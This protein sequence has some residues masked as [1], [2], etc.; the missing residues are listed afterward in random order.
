MPHFDNTLLNEIT[1]DQLEV[2]QNER[3]QKTRKDN[4]L[5]LLNTRIN[6]I[7]GTLVNILS[8]ASHEYGFPYLFKHNKALRKEK[9]QD[10]PFIDRNAHLSRGG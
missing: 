6:N 3:L 10:S 7:L 1:L 2:R 8:S 9:P 4:E 5:V